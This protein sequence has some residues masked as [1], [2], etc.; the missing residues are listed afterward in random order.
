MR[1]VLVVA[2]FAALGCVAGL[3]HTWSEFSDVDERMELPATVQ[4]GEVSSVA[5]SGLLPDDNEGIPKA[6]LVGDASNDFG[7]LH[8]DQSKSYSFT[9]RND[10]DA[11]LHI[12]KQTVSCSM[13]VQT[14][15]ETAKV[16][17]GE[18]VKIPVTL[19]ARK[20]GPELSEALEVRTNDPSHDVIRFELIAYVSEAAGASVSELALG[21][22]STD[23]GTNATFRV[24][25]FN[26]QPLEI[27]ECKM[28][29]GDRTEFFDWQIS[30]LSPEAVKEGQRHAVFGKEVKVQVKPGLPVGP[31]DQN[32][33]IVARSGEE[34]II[35]LPVSGRVTGDVSIIG[36]STFSPENSLLSIGRLLAGEG[37]SVKLHLMV[38]GD[39]QEDV[40]VT[41]G[42]CQPAEYLSATIG[43]PKTMQSGR[44]RLIPLNIEVSKD[45]P[46]VN[47]LGGERSSV[48]KIVLQT[49]HPTAKELT[50]FVRFAVE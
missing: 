47:H 28:Q 37:A 2:A 38:K 48:G 6:I 32:F 46:P 13:C 24:Y 43:E 19:T 36:G 3:A 33:T 49:T 42:E 14:T 21:T 22:V 23:Q 1:L 45:A 30:D 15:F 27:L 9:V 31:V 34:V 10:G 50:L 40:K 7:V 39:H 4:V 16:R 26:E 11:D 25:G 8:K 29:A 44:A 35:N 18:E 5:K 41:V 12:E 20:P 17:P